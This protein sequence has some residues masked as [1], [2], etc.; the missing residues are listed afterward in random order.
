MAICASLSREELARAI[1]SNNLVRWTSKSIA[2]ARELR[3]PLDS[4]RAAGFAVSDEQVQI[5]VRSIGAVI[6]DVNER[7]VGAVAAGFPKSELN[8]K[9]YK[10]VG[11]QVVAFARS[12]SLLI[13]HLL[14]LGVEVG[15]GY[16]GPQEAVPEVM[17][18]RK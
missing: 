12:L 9:D 2:T 16:L 11:R 15:D 7:V 4:I 8:E 17:Q 13:T 1:P 3:K 14:S 6:K 10:R 18:S 5:G